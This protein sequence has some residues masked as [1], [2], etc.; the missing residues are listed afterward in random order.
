MLPLRG[1]QKKYWIH[2]FTVWLRTLLSLLPRRI[3][4][5]RP[6]HTL[7][8]FTATREIRGFPIHLHQGNQNMATHN[9]CQIRAVHGTW[10]GPD[11]R[12]RWGGG[13]L[14]VAWDSS[15]AC[16]YVCY[17]PSPPWGRFVTQIYGSRCYL[18]SKS[19]PHTSHTHTHTADPH[20]SFTYRHTLPG[21]GWGV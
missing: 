6:R 1:A 7:A 12:L 14:S 18:T 20:T 8:F 11:Q 2:V 16:V 9:L 15:H 21:H 4:F 19:A 13:G 10:C 3:A 17:P 5:F